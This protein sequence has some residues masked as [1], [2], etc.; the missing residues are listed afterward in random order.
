MAY[1][2][3]FH[4]G[5][6]QRC[7]YSGRPRSAVTK[8]NI[9]KIKSI[10]VKDVHFTVGQ[11]AQMTNLGL[12]SVHFVLKKIFQVTKISVSA[13]YLNG[14]EIMVRTPVPQ[15]PLCTKLHLRNRI[16]YFITKTRLYNSNPFEPHFYIVKLG[17]TG[18]TLFF[19]FLVENINCGYS[20]EPPHRGGS[21]EHPQSIF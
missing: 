19:L 12:V 20:L 18:Y 15:L 6:R 21:N 5:I 4:L 16:T 2:I 1:K 8:S 10:I 13:R 17:F 3:Q 14:V 9:N 7:P 11:L